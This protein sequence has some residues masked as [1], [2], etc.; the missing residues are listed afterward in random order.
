MG[1]QEPRLEDAER[2]QARF[3]KQSQAQTRITESSY[4]CEI[5]PNDNPEEPKL[6]P[7]DIVKIKAGVRNEMRTTAQQKELANR[8]AKRKTKEKMG[9][10]SRKAQRKKK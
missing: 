9:K 6:S 8:V 4:G 5:V 3:A 10:A 7:E 2:I 1:P